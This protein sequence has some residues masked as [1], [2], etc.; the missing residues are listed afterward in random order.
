MFLEGRER[1]IHYLAPDHL[2]QDYSF[3]YLNWNVGCKLGGKLYENEDELNDKEKWDRDKYGY[4][5][6]IEV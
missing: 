1:E 3:V 2:Q 5:E 4:L 6:E